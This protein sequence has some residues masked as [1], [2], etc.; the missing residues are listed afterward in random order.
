MPLAKIH[1]IEGRYD[2]A[3]I[4]KVILSLPVAWLPRSCGAA[5][6]LRRTGSDNTFWSLTII[7]SGT[8]AS[9]ALTSVSPTS[10]P[11]SGNRIV[12][13]SMRIKAEG[14]APWERNDEQQ[15]I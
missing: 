9:S 5:K 2:E 6:R 8:S 14:I 4:A 12:Q 3:R 13:P 7:S 1:I 11:S 10:R 15:D